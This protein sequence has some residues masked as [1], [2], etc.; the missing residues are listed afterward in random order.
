MEK[1]RDM[2]RARLLQELERFIFEQEEIDPAELLSIAADECLVQGDRVNAR[3]FAV[4]ACCLDHDHQDSLWYIREAENRRSE[5][6]KMFRVVASGPNR[7]LD[8][9]YCAVQ[10]H[11]VSDEPDDVLT[12]VRELE[13][14]M[15][16]LKLEILDSVSR[17]DLPWGVY[18]RSPWVTSGKKS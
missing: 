5:G 14:D 3:R 4:R 2:V 1:V 9:R 17:P 12:Y 10:Y 15:P 18:W 7:F 6:A 8:R 16:E 11:V 13:P